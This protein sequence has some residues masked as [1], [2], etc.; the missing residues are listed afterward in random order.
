VAETDLTTY[1]ILTRS[2]DRYVVYE[3]FYHD[4]IV[5]HRFKVSWN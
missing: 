5:N 3:T 2:V 1:T 4:K